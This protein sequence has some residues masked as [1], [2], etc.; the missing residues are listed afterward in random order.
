MVELNIIITELINVVHKWHTIK[1]FK[2]AATSP[3]YPASTG[4]VK[5]ATSG[6]MAAPGHL[7][8][9]T[10]AIHSSDTFFSCLSLQELS[11]RSCAQWQHLLF[12]LPSSPT[13]ILPQPKLPV[14]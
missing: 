2:V 10:G 11:Q 5:M 3:S 9:H 14:V 7:S 1:T 13:D 4:A 12:S 6:K 8:T